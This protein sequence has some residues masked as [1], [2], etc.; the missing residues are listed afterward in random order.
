MT[1]HQGA[2]GYGRIPLEV[3][4]ALGFYVYLL[5]DPRDHQVF[6]VGKGGGSRVYAHV[7]DADG[8]GGEDRE[9]ERAKVARI[10]AI[11]D[12]GLKVEH[13]FARTGLT[14]S[15]LALV[16]EQSVIDALRA[17]GIPLTNLQG[18][19]D[20]AVHG[21][22]TVE[23]AV[24]RLSAPPA[25]SCPEPI[26]IFV[27]NRAWRLDLSADE[28]YQVTSGHWRVSR[29]AREKARYAFGVAFGLVRGVYRVESWFPSPLP[30]EDRRWGFV[31]S[32][33]PEMAHFLGTSV[34]HLVSEHA[35]NPVRL[36]LDGLPGSGLD[37]P[38]VT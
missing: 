3:A 31:G 29:R 20:S 9:V 5:R 21:L 32:P 10:R 34:R 2:A 37:G 22:A 35:Q 13:L 30:G 15:E 6:Y 27:V 16:V 23:A 1:D 26:V 12:A 28:V 38:T 36:C 17:A 19:H 24:A 4:E 25:P 8:E 14:T 33:A 7:G 11:H 18:G